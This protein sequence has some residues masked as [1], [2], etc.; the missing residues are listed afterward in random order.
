MDIIRDIEGVELIYRSGEEDFEVSL[1]PNI[2]IFYHPVT[3]ILFC[4]WYGRPTEEKIREYGAVIFNKFKAYGC[5]KVFNDNRKKRGDF[6]FSIDWTKNTW[7]PLMIDEGGML[8]FAWILSAD[9]FTKLSTD[10]AF[11]DFPQVKLFT[12]GNEGYKWL[13]TNIPKNYEIGC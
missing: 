13:L 10:D 2:E 1:N 11:P 4:D 8:R 6:P 9:F 7:F 5:T 12:S 3:K